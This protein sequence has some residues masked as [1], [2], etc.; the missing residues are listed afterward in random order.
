MR[1]GFVFVAVAFLVSSLWYVQA[2]ERV[3]PPLRDLGQKKHEAEIS[4]RPHE[5]G[6]LEPEFGEMKKSVQK[7]PALIVPA[8]PPTLQDKLAQGWRLY[9]R[10][11]YAKA[12]PYPGIGCSRCSNGK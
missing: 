8:S 6:L 12:I 3:R 2:Q 11:D 10:G 7:K 1:K 4:Q 9:K 5:S